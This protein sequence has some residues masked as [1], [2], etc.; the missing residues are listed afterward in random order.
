MLYRATVIY[1]AVAAIAGAILAVGTKEYVANFGFLVFGAL[2]GTGSVFFIEELRRER[3]KTT[4]TLSLFY[5][6]AN[7]VARCCFDFEDP[8]HKFLARAES[9]DEFRLRK[10]ISE[11]PIIYPAVAPQLSML[12]EG[13]PLAVMD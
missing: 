12:E 9:M 13:A 7:R 5:E 11:P 2:I 4:M 6:L 8:W 3:E 10:F 1:L